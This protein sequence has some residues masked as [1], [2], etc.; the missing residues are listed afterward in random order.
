MGYSLLPSLGF[1]YLPL[2][3]FHYHVQLL[4]PSAWFHWNLHLMTNPNVLGIKVILEWCRALPHVLDGLLGAGSL[5]IVG[6]S[7]ILGG[8]EGTDRSTVVVVVVVVGHVD[9]TVEGAKHPMSNFMHFLLLLLLFI[10]LPKLVS[11]TGVKG[12]KLLL[13]IFCN[14]LPK[15][16]QRLHLS[17]SRTIWSCLGCH[18]SSICVDAIH[19]LDGHFYVYHVF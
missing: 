10:F 3:F 4:S 8:L 18:V 13:L 2:L 19:S 11:L 16:R 12:L 9:T 17:A 1:C 7:K 14:F 5:G 15:G 6:T